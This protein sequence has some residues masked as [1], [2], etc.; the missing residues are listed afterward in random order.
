MMTSTHSLIQIEK[1]PFSGLLV[2][3]S[4]QL[5]SMI[6]VITLTAVVAVVATITAVAVTTVASY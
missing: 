2:A 3:F 1:E 6:A 4:K 5:S